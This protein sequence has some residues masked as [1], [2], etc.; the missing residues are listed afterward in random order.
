MRVALDTA[1][2]VLPPSPACTTGHAQATSY[3]GAVVVVVGYCCYFVSATEPCPGG[4]GD[5]RQGRV[6]FLLVVDKIC[7]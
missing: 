5:P 7:K 3:T 6:R 1:H 2:E 4:T